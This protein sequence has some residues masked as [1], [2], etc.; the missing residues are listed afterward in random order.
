MAASGV[1]TFKAHDIQG[2][3]QKGEIAGTSKQAV[4]D[5]L[6]ARGLQQGSKVDLI[7]DFNAALGGPVKRDA[8]WFFGTWRRIATNSI[9]ANN[10]Y[11][12]GRPG[13]EDQWIQNQMVR[14]TWQASPRNKFTIYHDRYQRTPDGWKF[15]E[16]VYEVR[17]HDTSALTGAP[18]NARP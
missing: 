17:Y 15:T 18:P 2:I 10:F 14:L 12:D 7:T 1:Y 13:I 6:R 9:I 3:P 8:L 16:R 11:K 5:E 4:T